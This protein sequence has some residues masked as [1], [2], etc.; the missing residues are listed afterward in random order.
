MELLPYFHRQFAYNSWANRQVLQALPPADTHR[1][2]Q[3][4]AHILSAE[5]L[6]LERI[7]QQP[8]SYAVWPDFS[9][10]ECAAQLASM[11]ALWRKFLGEMSLQSLDR[12]ISYKNTKG[13]LWNDSVLD[14][15]S[16]VLFHSAYHRG[17]I[18]SAMRAAGVQPAYTD[19]I[20]AVRQ[21]MIE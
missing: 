12:R 8:Q 6:W 16:H 18:A 21:H 20:H 9:A 15:L 10:A 14:I 19:F 2:C 3:L 7:R 11:D 4:F 1:Y 13:E 5:R 17:Q